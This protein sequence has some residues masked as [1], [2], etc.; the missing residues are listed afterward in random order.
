MDWTILMALL[1]LIVV[2]MFVFVIVQ[3]IDMLK[4]RKL[5]KQTKLVLII[6]FILASFLTAIIYWIW[7]KV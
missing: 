4:S 6:L 1:F 3:F 7:K 2:L 5:K